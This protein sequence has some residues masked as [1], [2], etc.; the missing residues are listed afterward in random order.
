MVGIDIQY[1]KRDTSE[2]Y[3]RIK[4]SGLE[5]IIWKN[6]TINKNNE[7]ERLGFIESINPI[8][9]LNASLIK[10]YQ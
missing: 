4:D 5:T 9:R 10:I 7:E 8:N 6:F 1:H 2:V 3:Q